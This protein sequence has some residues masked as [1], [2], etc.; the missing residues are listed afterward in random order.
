MDKI[1]FEAITDF[2]FGKKFLYN[3]FWV[4]KFNFDEKNKLKNYKVYDIKIPEILKTDVRNIVKNHIPYSFAIKAEFKLN[5]PLHIKDD[6]E[7]Y[8]I[9]NPMLKEKVFKIPMIRGSSWKGTL[10]KAGIDIFKEEANLEYLR[11]IFRIFGVGN[12]EYRELFDENDK[13]IKDNILLFLTLEM[14]VDVR[15]DLEEQLAQYFKTKA[16]KGRAVFYPTYFNKLSLEVINPHD[17]RTKAGTKPIF[18][19][20]VPKSSYGELQIVYIPFDRIL[21][22]DEEIKKEAENDLKFLQKCIDKVAQNGVGAKT[23]LGWGKFEIE[24]KECVWSRK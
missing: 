12:S 13:V 11:S 14:G 4:N 7:F 1:F 6:D 10:L 22:K 9:P 18:Y 5:A 8:I 17:R 20:V 21:K 3:D 23:K 2:R 15:K 19:E 16:Q 24:K